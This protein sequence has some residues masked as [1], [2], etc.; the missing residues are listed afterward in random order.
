MTRWDRLDYTKSQIKNNWYSFNEMRFYGEYSF[1]MYF[2]YLFPSI[3]N[4]DSAEVDP[5]DWD[6]D[7]EP[8]VSFIINIFAIIFGMAGI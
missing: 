4:F 7:H 3:S 5:H 8:I 2:H 6:G 1:H